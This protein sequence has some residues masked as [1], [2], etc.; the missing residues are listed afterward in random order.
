[1]KKRA[2]VRGW[3]LHEKGY[4]FHISIFP[5]FTLFV[6]WK[7]VAKNSELKGRAYTQ[8]RCV[9]L[10]CFSTRF[11]DEEK[12]SRRLRW[13]WEV[14]EWKLGTKN[15]S[16]FSFFLG[17]VLKKVK[18]VS[19]FRWDVN[20]RLFKRLFSLV[21]L[22]CTDVGSKTWH[23]VPQPD[24]YREYREINSTPSPCIKAVVNGG[25]NGRINF[26]F[27]IFLL[28]IPFLM[29]LSWHHCFASGNC[30]QWNARDVQHNNFNWTEK[31][32][33]DVKQLKISSLFSHL[34]VIA[35]SSIAICA[36]I[37]WQEL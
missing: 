18:K 27:H 4:F 23:F 11:R 30:R 36:F 15:L 21:V 35:Q 13:R 33:N 19:F 12:K 5:T 22:F 14:T 9:V 6:K 25:L 37:S 7:K 26:H 24:E 16:F 17:T 10:S 28:V 3:K 29:S 8:Q 2:E 31:N 34:A 1:M 20:C 32:L